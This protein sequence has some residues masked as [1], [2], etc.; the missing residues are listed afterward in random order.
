MLA[1][2]LSNRSVEDFCRRWKVNELSV[3]RGADDPSPDALGLFAQFDPATTWSL[4]DRLRMQDE[5]SALLGRAVTLRSRHADRIRRG[6]QRAM[7]VVY[8]A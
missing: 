4:L 8:N 7:Q 5:L 2:D 1:L 3:A 6:G